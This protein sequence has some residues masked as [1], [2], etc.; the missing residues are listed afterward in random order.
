MRE[1]LP[2]TRRGVTHK[3]VIHAQPELCPHCKGI[4]HEGR[5][6]FFLTVGLYPDGRPGE[7]FLH[8]DAAGSTLDGFASMWSTA[9]SMCLQA[10]IPLE[11]LVK[12]FSYQEFEPQGMTENDGIRTA[13][14]IV[15]YVIRYLEMLVKKA[16]ETKP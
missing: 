16:E 3:G 9:L 1:R 10:G 8:M 5:V 11:T 15:D 12:K 4:V 6:K 13:R 7:V 2:T 14:S